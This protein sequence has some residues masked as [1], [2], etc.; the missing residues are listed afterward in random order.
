VK[1]LK[2]IDFIVT[3]P[4]ADT[5]GNILRHIFIEQLSGLK[6]VHLVENLG[7]KG[8]FTAIKN[9]KFLLGNSSSGIIE[10]AS[11]GKYVIDLGDR[12]KGRITGRNVLKCAIKAVEIEK[13]IA[14]IDT[15]PK[16]DGSNIYWKSGAAKQII[17]LLKGYNK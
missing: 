16:L 6:N 11:F 8:Y 2:D 17:Q 1:N 13:L 9:C 3:M 12:Q 10:A 14:T 5:F 15:L 4:N 7:T